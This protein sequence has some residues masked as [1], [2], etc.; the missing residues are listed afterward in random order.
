MS[1]PSSVPSLSPVTPTA[2]SKLRAFSGVQPTGKLHLGNYLGAIKPWVQH[3]HARENVFC[4]V[5]L[6]A[7][8]I[9]EVVNPAQ[10]RANCRG[11]VA[12]FLAS[13]IDPAH[14]NIFIQSHIRE[15]AELQWLLNCVTPLGWLDRMTQFKSKAEGRETVGAGLLNYPV[16]QAADILLYD[17]DVVILIMTRLHILVLIY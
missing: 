15:H 1:T 4:V 16:L 10:L 6:H 14:S 3:Q 17:T 8:T 2:P 12:A 7:L 11:V 5:D 9:P 13:G